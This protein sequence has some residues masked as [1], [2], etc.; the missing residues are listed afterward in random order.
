MIFPSNPLLPGKPNLFFLQ[1][2]QEAKKAFVLDLEA[3]AAGDP[4]K[5][6][7]RIPANAGPQWYRGWM[8]PSDQYLRLADTLQEKGSPLIVSGD[9]YVK[10]HHFPSWYP[11]F[12]HLTPKS[13]WSTSWQA[14]SPPSE[15]GPYFL[16]D[17]VKSCKTA[18]DDACYAPDLASLPKVVERMVK[19]RAEAFEWGVVIR[20]FEEFEPGEARIFWLDGEP[21]LR[22]PHP[23]QRG[24]TFILPPSEVLMDVRKAVQALG[25]RFVTTDLAKR[26]DGVWRVIE[27][28]DGQVSDVGEDAMAMLLSRVLSL[29]GTKDVHRCTHLYGDKPGD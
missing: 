13:T 17:W 11:V 21:I 10:A 14:P 24:E 26:T 9:D 15:N 3:L 1:E 7:R 5:A 23:V 16:K 25:C 6:T 8:I 22:L 18:W 27:V 29:V 2:F 12:E 4:V 20:C 19:T 28:G